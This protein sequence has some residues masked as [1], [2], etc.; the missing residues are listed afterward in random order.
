L[1]IRLY[2]KSLSN[3]IIYQKFENI[4]IDNNLQEHQWKCW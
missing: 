4:R 3:A 2:K 1:V